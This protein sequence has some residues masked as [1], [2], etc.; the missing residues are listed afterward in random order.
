MSKTYEWSIETAAARLAEAKGRLEQDDP[1]LKAVFTQTFFDEAEADIS[2]LGRSPQSAL[3]GAIVSIK[4]LLDVK[5]F[6]T[7]AGTRF[8]Q[9]DAPAAKDAATVGRLREAGAVLIGHTNMTELAYSGLGLNP[10]YGTPENAV[11]KGRIPGGSTSGGAVS[12]ARNVADIALGT[13]TGGSLRIPAAFN[14]IVGFKPTQ[15]TVSREGCK[16]L[17]RSLDSVGPMA[18]TVAACDLAYTVL[19]GENAGDRLLS[20]AEFVIPSNYG[21]DDLEPAVSKAFDTAVGR[22][23]AAGFAVGKARIDA[24]EQLKALPIWHFASIECRAEYDHAYKHHKELID[25]RIA[26]STRMGRADEVDA[27][28]YRKTLN[29]RAD[30]IELFRREMAGKV[31]LMPTVPI[32]PP[33]FEALEDDD[34]FSRINLQVLRNP[35]I[36]N[37]MDS[38]SISVP[39]ARDGA[40]IGIMMTACGGHDRALLSL[41]AEVEASLDL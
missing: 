25:P 6:V 31:L 10:H 30:L 33:S 14:G 35:S 8:L 28:A 21:M 20:D 13:D 37:V 22:L 16:A 29:R 7:R 26:G 34:A 39:Y 15:K 40:P 12:V 24:L 19:A 18:R 5:G 3:A 11:L 41:A 9:K 2:Q 36:A 38:C 27:V 17:S 23:T 1:C 32:L 4:D